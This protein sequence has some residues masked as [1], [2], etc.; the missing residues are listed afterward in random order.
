MAEGKLGL[1]V[2]RGAG[3]TSRTDMWWVQPAVVVLVFGSFIGYSTWAAFQNDHYT[4]GNYLSPMYSPALFSDPTESAKTESKG[5]RAKDQEHHTFFGAKPG[6]WPAWLIFSPALL[7]FPFPG[8]FRFTCYY[9]RG[10]YYKSFW[11]DPLNCAV[12]EPRASY[13]G[14]NSLP[15][16]LQNVHRY[17]LY[18]AIIFIV[19]L[20]YDAIQGF[21][22][23]TE[24][25]RRFGVGVGTLVLVLNAVL[26]G[27]YTFGCHSFRHL[28][29]GS[30]DRLSESPT[31]K[32]IYDCV[33]CLNRSHMAWAWCSL[34]WVAFTD[35]YVRLCSMGIW[36]DFRVVF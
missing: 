3:E 4:Y 9:Y 21:F 23:Y 30:K 33:S 19:L 14:E 2:V 15:L 22:F 28:V 26:L 10:A 18:F 17:A 31:Q 36:T 16:I 1:P 27:G 32:Q 12:G 20:T 29:G 8:L 24:N 6:W 11:A 34:F 5:Q 25:G 13:W 7:I 35:I